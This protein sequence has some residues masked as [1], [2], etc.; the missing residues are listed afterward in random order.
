MARTTVTINDRVITLPPRL[1]AMVHL[2][3]R[4]EKT[5]C[6]LDTCVVE[7]HCGKNGNGAVSGEVKV[8]L[9]VPLE[10]NHN[11]TT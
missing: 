5:I 3:V 1:A 8:K 7:F 4:F 11:G 2:L 6:P 10:P 9:V